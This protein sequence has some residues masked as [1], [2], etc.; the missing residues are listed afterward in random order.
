MS[1]AA[2]LVVVLGALL[3]IA[4][5]LILWHATGR[6]G[7]TRYF[8]EAREAERAQREPSLAD[9]FE[10]TGL[11]DERG[12]LEDLPNRFALGLL[13]SGPDHHA[14]SVFTLVAPATLA[15]LAALLLRPRTKP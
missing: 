8:D 1:R 10:G 12:V 6:A 2:R 5:S 4:Q 15:L 14:V 7:F 13:P 9:L 11:H 3:V